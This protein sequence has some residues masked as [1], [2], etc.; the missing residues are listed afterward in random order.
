[1]AFSN[2]ISMD[3]PM[4]APE[5]TAKKEPKTIEVKFLIHATLGSSLQFAKGATAILPADRAKHLK[6][7]KIIKFL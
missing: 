4:T 6:K 7:K 3:T 5:P 1:M 2:L